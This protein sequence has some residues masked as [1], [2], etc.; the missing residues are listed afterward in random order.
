[1]KKIFI[2]T[3]QTATGKTALAI[4]LAQKHKGEIVNSDSRHVY[5]QLDIVSGKDL[6]TLE[7]IPH[8]LFSIIDP[9]KD[10]SSYDWSQRATQCINTLSQRDV[11]PILVGGSYFYIKH[12]L[13]GVRTEGTP[14]DWNLRNKLNKMT[15]KELQKRASQLI[16]ELKQKNE[17][18][19]SDWNNPR[20][21]I[22]KIEILSSK[23]T[24]P[25]GVPLSH[26]GDEF[27]KIEIVG[28]RHQSKELLTERIQK[29]VAKR[30]NQGAF[31]EV[32][33]LIKKGYDRDT[34][35]LMTI[36]YQQIVKFLKGEI[37]EAKAIEDW[38]NKETQ[39][40]KRQYSFMKTNP[41]IKWT[42]V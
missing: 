30:I 17:M 4:K 36:G 16:N 18:N 34:P 31:K 42:E 11:A 13:D 29:R 8:H 23:H 39:Y 9:E 38:I 20:R 37:T 14:A 15:V 33:D 41:N 2:I 10:F 35:G 6:E 27:G 26:R 5:K 22:R 7:N 24:D 21:L 3:G 28:L 25:V 1:M 40:A 19:Q 32:E 12:L